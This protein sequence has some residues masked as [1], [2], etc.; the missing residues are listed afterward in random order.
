MQ[1][2]LLLAFAFAILGGCAAQTEGAATDA[3]VR[4]YERDDG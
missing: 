1:K 4:S 3:L 2:N